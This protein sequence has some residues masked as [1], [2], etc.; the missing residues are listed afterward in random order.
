MT[1]RDMTRRKFIGL[2]TLVALGTSVLGPYGCKDNQGLGSYEPGMNPQKKLVEILRNYSEITGGWHG[3]KGPKIQIS[4][5]YGKGDFQGH[6]SHPIGSTSPGVDLAVPEG[7]PLVLPGHG[8][9]YNEITSENGSIN[10]VSRLLA[11]GWYTV[12][13][14]HLSEILVDSRFNLSFG[15]G[16]Q[17]MVS[18]NEIVAL[19]GASGLYSVG[20]HLHFGLFHKKVNGGPKYFDDPFKKGID[21]GHPVFSDARTNLSIPAYMRI[22]ALSEAMGKLEKDVTNWP[23]EGKIGEVRG[24]LLEW[25]NYLK[26]ISGTDFLDSPH[27][28]DMRAYLLKITAADDSEEEIKDPWTPESKVYTWMLRIAGFSTDTS[29]EVILNLPLISP[30]ILNR[31][32]IAVYENGPFV[33][34]RDFRRL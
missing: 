30:K 24:N 25:N 3:T 14:S 22:Y 10:L 31:Y 16:I 1:R 33:S 18:Q 15:E 13:F 11:N 28:Q 12:V 23:K 19:S 8:G 21:G 29:Q 20:A 27:F 2:A 9:I 7:T 26:G 6:M 4:S 17:R 5:A 32:K 34:T